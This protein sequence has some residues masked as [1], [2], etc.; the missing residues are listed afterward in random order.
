M[1]DGDIWELSISYKNGNIVEYKGRS[2]YPLNFEA[3][4]RLNEKLISEGIGGHAG[5]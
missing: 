3:F 5:Y 4:E 2:N 1:I